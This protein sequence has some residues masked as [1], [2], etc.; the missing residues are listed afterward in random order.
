MI[1]I[2]RAK[3]IA[4]GIRRGLKIERIVEEMNRNAVTINTCA[5]N[6]IQASSRDEL[7]ET[8]CGEREIFLFPTTE[9]SKYCPFCGRS[10]E[11]SDEE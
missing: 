7:V 4:Y 8:S 1:D 2:N 10:I 3:D 11:T 9:K 5:W 6:R